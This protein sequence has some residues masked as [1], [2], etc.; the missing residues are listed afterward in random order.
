MG[1]L[2]SVR[3]LELLPG[4][5][6][7]LQSFTYLLLPRSRVFTRARIVCCAHERRALCAGEFG[8]RNVVGRYGVSF[9]SNAPVNPKERSK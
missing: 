1:F 6:D 2:V 4:V 5:A 7:Y 3:G 8:R 9:R